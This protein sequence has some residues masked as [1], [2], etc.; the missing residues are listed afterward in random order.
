MD[1]DYYLYINQLHWKLSQLKPV[2]ITG[3]VAGFPFNAQTITAATSSG[4]V[5][6]YRYQYFNKKAYLYIYKTN[7][8]WFDRVIY[9]YLYLYCYIRVSIN[10][11]IY[12]VSKHVWTLNC[13][14][15]CIF[16]CSALTWS[17][18]IYKRFDIPDVQTLIL[19]VPCTSIF[20]QW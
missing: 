7:G 14:T 20:I 6:L 19:Y 1:Y 12:S 3:V 5:Q 16:I 10:Y 17:F 2:C 9:T 8:R 4:S 15:Q 13:S 18:I 11:N